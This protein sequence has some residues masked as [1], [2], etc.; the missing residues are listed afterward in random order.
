MFISTFCQAWYLNSSGGYADKEVR[1]HILKNGGTTMQENILYDDEFIR[2]L[3]RTDGVYIETRKRG[4]SF[5]QLNQLLAAHPRIEISSFTVLKN[6][7]NNITSQPEKIG[8]LKERMDVELLDNNL[9]AVI[10]FHLTREE[11]ELK[12]RE[13]LIREVSQKLKETGVVFGIKSEV[14]SGELSTDTHYTIAQGIS[15]VN[16]KDS[17]VRMFENQDAKPEVNDEGKV[18][19]Y[20]LKLINRVIAGDRLGERI[21]ATRGVPGKSVKGEE[22]K[23]TDGKTFSLPYDK[24]TVIETLEAGKT[25]LTSRIPGAVSF[26]DGR[27]MVS[28]HLEIEGNVDFRTGNINFDGYLTIKGTVA[29]GFMVTATKDIEI[30]GSLGLGNVKGIVSTGGSI[31]IKG[32]VASK[33]KAEI[34]A[35]NNFYAKFVDNT[36]IRC[37][38]IAHIGYYCINSVIH[39]KEV[40][41]DSSNGHII[42]GHIT[43]EIKMVTPTLGSEMEMR[44]VVE[45]T[46]FDRNSLKEE[47]EGIVG[48][49]I[50]L[51]NEQQKIKQQLS[52][53][54]GQTTQNTYQRNEYNN[55]IEKLLSLKDR[56]MELEQSKK[57]ISEYL[58]ARGD[59]E[60]AVTKKIH[61]NCR[62]SIGKISVEV[63]N[64][65]SAIVF[66]LQKDEIK[67]V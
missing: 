53:T 45:V 63:G 33:G 27:I 23:A 48:K 25:V 32:G 58:K 2:L 9:K 46:G 20:E 35:A 43:A 40:I 51:R 7:L 50:E 19:F 36:Y 65:S 30:N 31:F 61:P 28:D 34:R 16:G 21:E 15:P 47:S 55:C 17:I 59:G 12:N 44:T 8:H 29:D 49:I 5:E 56:I 1:G 52:R 22:I 10:V 60:I 37:G 26:R 24:N 6:A 18:D 62:L 11:L 66:Y 41:V 14:M 42:G 3:H 54:E 64:P 57:N 38:G 39:A 67:Q 13:V 4:L